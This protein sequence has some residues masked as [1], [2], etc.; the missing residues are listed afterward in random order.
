MTRGGHGDGALS[1]ALRIGEVVVAGIRSPVREAGPTGSSEAVVFVHGNPG[2]GADWE[3]L[4]PL[5]GR[6]GRAVAVDL[7]GFG[8]AGKPR[9]F[10]YSVRGYA[11]HLHAVLE[12]LG[13]ERAHLVLHDFGGL[14]GLQW[15]ADHPDAFRS[16]VL[17]GVG[18]LPGYRWHL[19]ARIWRTPVLGELSMLTVARAPFR[20]ALRAGHPRGLPRELLDRMFDDFDA[21]TRRAVLRLYR[22]TDDPGGL[23]VALADRLRALDRPA[24]VLWGAHDLYL[25]VRYA[26]RQREV[27]P[28]ADVHV[29]G[30]SGHWL[31]A[32]APDETA[33]LVV[34]FLAAALADQ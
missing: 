23:G 26:E 33:R 4:L 27:F 7:P 11:G 5:V 21:G 10:D 2:S 12:E 28:R 19:Y 31:F 34:P 1:P 13:V 9:D 17:L 25:P 3:A 24:L 8:Q 6:H 22:A 30:D 18:V 15:A 20:T 32:D 14:W 29:L 16:V